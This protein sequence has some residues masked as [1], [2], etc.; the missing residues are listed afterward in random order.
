MPVIPE[1]EKQRQE[2]KASLGYI[3]SLRSPCVIMRPCI[4]KERERERERREGQSEG[5]REKK[6]T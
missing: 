6:V 4:V 2:F 5:W 1:F 3:V